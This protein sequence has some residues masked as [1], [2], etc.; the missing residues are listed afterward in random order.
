MAKVRAVIEADSGTLLV[1]FPQ[2]IYALYEKLRSVGIRHSPSNIP[3]ADEEDG[4]IRVKLYA[5]DDV[6]NR[7][8]STREWQ[9][10]DE[11]VF[12]RVQVSTPMGDFPFATHYCLTV[13]NVDPAAT[14]LTFRFD[15]YGEVRLSLTVPLKGG[16]ADG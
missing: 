11:T 1:D 8:S 5:E 7:Y 9:A 3:I 13:T 4:A 16:E 14:Q 6:G 2:G 15:R 12:S 10:L